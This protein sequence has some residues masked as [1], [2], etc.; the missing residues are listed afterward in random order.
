MF[1][2]LSEMKLS[3]FSLKMCYEK[4][5]LLHIIVVYIIS[6][7]TISQE[8]FDQSPGLFNFL[9]AKE[10]FYVSSVSRLLVEVW[11]CRIIRKNVKNKSFPVLSIG[12]NNEKS[13]S[14][15]SKVSLYSDILNCCICNDV[16][17]SLWIC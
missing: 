12:G 3:E 14:V 7:L 17:S 15:Q 11:Y 8:Y 9:F 6:E 4:C 1:C 10:S 5:L 2:S 16:Q 13:D